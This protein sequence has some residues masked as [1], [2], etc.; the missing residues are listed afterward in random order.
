MKESFLLSSH[1]LRNTFDKAV[2]YVNSDSSDEP[3]QKLIEN[4]LERIHHL[5]A[6]KN[7][8]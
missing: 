2:A 7:Q 3:G 1:Y 6:I 4:L 8:Y 5:D